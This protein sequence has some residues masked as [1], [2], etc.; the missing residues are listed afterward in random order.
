VQSD[1]SW[2]LAVFLALGSLVAF[3]IGLA[4]HDGGFAVVVFWVTALT[5]GVL[6]SVVVQKYQQRRHP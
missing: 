5:V 3:F 2:S 1:A 4:L 6:G